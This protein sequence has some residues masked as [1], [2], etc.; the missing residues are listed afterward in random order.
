MT[1]G[2]GI[3]PRG[4]SVQ[5]TQ[6][7]FYIP[8]EDPETTRSDQ[9]NGDEPVF[10]KDAKLYGAG[11]AGEGADAGTIW[12]PNSGQPTWFSDSSLD[13]TSAPVPNDSSYVD[14]LYLLS[15]PPFNNALEWPSFDESAGEKYVTLG[16]P[17]SIASRSGSLI[18]ADGFNDDAIEIMPEPM[19]TSPKRRRAATKKPVLGTSASSSDETPTCKQSSPKRRKSIPSK[20]APPANPS[21]TI[22][23]IT[24]KVLARFSIDAFNL[25]PAQLTMQQLSYIVELILA[26][27]QAN[28]DSANKSR[29]RKVQQVELLESRLVDA[30]VQNE[31]LKS[32]LKELEDRVK[33]KW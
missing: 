20:S 10:W 13:L 4:T 3:R 18:L 17:S 5:E 16:L 1:S 30:K 28:R 6:P 27:R 23:G 12:T 2:I 7:R 11:Y 14:Y 29:A 22:E 24:P 26:R 9:F 25:S 21:I 8:S 33:K 19:L 15:K 32:K 31:K